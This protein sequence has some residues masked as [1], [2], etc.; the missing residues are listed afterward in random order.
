MINI[1]IWTL[2]KA[3]ITISIGS[4]AASHGGL[5]SCYECA[6][7]NPENRLCDFGGTL[8]DPWASACCSPDNKSPYCTETGFNKCSPPYSQAGNLFYSHCRQVN[9][10]MCGTEEADMSL[11]AG[12]SK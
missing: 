3:L 7:L 12:L 10:T 8:P 5:K 11:E 1:Q 6:S 4:V 2:A 9:K